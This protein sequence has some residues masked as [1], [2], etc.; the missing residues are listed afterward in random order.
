M[1]NTVRPEAPFDRQE[2]HVADHLSRKTPRARCPRD[3]FAIAG[4]HCEGDAYDIFVPTVDFKAAL[5]PAH[6]GA[7]RLDLAIVGAIDPFPSTLLQQ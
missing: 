5:T 1:R 4:V 7:Q 2:H 6:V 3:D